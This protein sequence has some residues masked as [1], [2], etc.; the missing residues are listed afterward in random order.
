MSAPGPTWAEVQAAIQAWIVAATGLATDRVRWS[1]QGG[2]QPSTPGLWISLAVIAESSG[3]PWATVEDAAAPASGAEIVHVA[4]AMNTGTLSIQAFGG[5]A[6]GNGAPLALL[7]GLR[8]ALRLPSVQAAHAGI[9]GF[10]SFDAAT[11][12]P[13]V[14]DQTYFEPRAAMACR[15]FTA[16]EL[17]AT[18]A[19]V[20]TGT[21]IEHT[22]ITGEAE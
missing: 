5:A 18:A 15:F 8:L 12:V 14:R 17:R 4:R 9:V 6:A 16:A 21:Y 7:R 3:Q 11:S 13:G 22:E 1:D 2:K 19:G 20:E 10:G